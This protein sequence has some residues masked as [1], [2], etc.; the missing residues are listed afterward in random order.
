MELREASARYLPQLDSACP[1]GYKQT[2]LGVIPE[3]WSVRKLLSVVRSHNS[4]IYKSQSLY[5]HGCN[6]VGVSDI[7]SIDKVD[8]QFFA[9][10]PLSSQERAKHT[11]QCG[12]LLYGESSLVREGIART[13]Y[14]TERGTGTAFAWHTRRYSIDQQKLSSQYL[15]YYLQSRPA[16]AHMINQ[17]IQT[18]ITGINTVA[19]F[20]CPIIVPSFAEQEAIAQVLSDADALIESLEQLLAKKR[21]IKQ[22]AMQEL[23]TCKKRL[24]G[25]SGE[26]E[27]K[28]MGSVLKFQV[29]F[30][31]SSAFFN[32][33]GEGVRLV[34]NRDL[35][36]DDQVFHYSG[37]FDQEYLVRDGDVLVGMDGDFLPCYWAK[38]QAVLNQ[39]VGRIMPLAGLDRVFAFYYL[40]EPL[41]EIENTTSSTTVKH[42]SHGDIE[43]IE[44]PLPIVEEQTA[45]ASVLSDMDAELAALDEKLAKARALK[46]GMMQQL[47]TG[48]I[49]LV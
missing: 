46:Q 42:L 37:K 48:R 22:G 33:E 28:R 49:R 40:I 1:S 16:R 47:L 21:H 15:Y 36:S 3:E 8:G 27:V 6:I 35:K 10:V 38:G 2:E 45:I 19:Y 39:R 18:A 14:V 32:E 29:G 41:K 25:F 13:V 43:G 5:G 30:P 9:A 24:P 34:K 20:S 4:G 31:F 44:K 12:D 26:W 17:S 11:L 23:L 7:Y